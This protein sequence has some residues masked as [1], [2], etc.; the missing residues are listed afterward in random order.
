MT[1]SLVGRCRRTGQLGVAVASP[2][3]GIGA[4]TPWVRSRAGAVAVQNVVD[5][6]LG[7]EALDLLQSGLDAQSAL[8]LLMGGRNDGEYRQIL[9]IDSDGSTASFQGK[10]IKS[11]FCVT[12]G[13]HVIA[14][15][16]GLPTQ[17]ISEAM[18]RS[19][20]EATDGDLGERLVAGLLAGVAEGGE[21]L[22]VHSAALIVAAD[23]SWP[24]IDL[25]VDWHESLSVQILEGL[26]LAYRAQADDYVRA[27]LDP[28]GVSGLDIWNES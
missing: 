6:R 23:Q 15:G 12:A 5:P 25:R 16:C 13:E 2:E 20:E 24:L 9:V 21:D 1:F 22:T 11:T 8:S 10:A 27:A 4:R 14:G 26:W 19:F 17:V 18:V 3:I 7:H 28:G